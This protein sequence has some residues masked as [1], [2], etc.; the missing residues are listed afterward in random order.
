MKPMFRFSFRV[1]PDGKRIAS[2]ELYV[3]KDIWV[4][5]PS[6][7]TEDRATYEGQNAF[8][9][10]SP[11]GSH[12]AFRSDR[13]SA[14]LRIYVIN[15]ENSRDVIELTPGPYD[16]PSSWTADG[17][18]ILF[19]RGSGPTDVGGYQRHL[20][21]FRRSTE[22]RSRRGAATPAQERFPEISPDGKWLAYTSN[23]SGRAEL[24]VQPYPGPGQ[25]VTVTS[26][27]AQESAWSKNS[28]EL[29]YRNGIRMMAVRFKISGTEFVSEKPTKLFERPALGGG[30]NVR[31]NFDVAPD[32]RFLLNQPMTERAEERDRKIFP[33][34]LRFIL[35]WTD[36]VQR[37]LASAR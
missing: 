8:P 37:L 27:G 21:G 17:K 25:R 22:S 36:E 13:S 3:N 23:E 24:Y 14:G 6:R 11:D 1:L 34:T 4:F 29:F 31:A 15:A 35:N 28:N 5:D 2:S 32:G 18:E 26:D 10:W 12:M 20:C 33:T 30:G 16:V 9:I 19:T 7:G